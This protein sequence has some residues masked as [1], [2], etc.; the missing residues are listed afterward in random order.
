M[1]LYSW[2]E[3]GTILLPAAVHA[4]DISNF[5]AGILDIPEFQLPSPAPYPLQFTYNPFPYLPPE[6]IVSIL[7]E[8]S[9]DSIPSLFQTNHF[10]QLHIEIYKRQIIK[11]RTQK[12]P[13]QILE[14]YSTIHDV[15]FEVIYAS[16]EAWTVLSKFERK[17]NI[18]L[19]L[20]QLLQ[21]YLSTS[22]TT[23]P[24]SFKFN[25]FTSSRFYRAFLRHWESRRTWFF[26][27]Q[28]W[29]EALLD[30]F[31]I[32]ENSTR[33]EIC[34]IIHLQMLYRTILSHLPWSS[35]LPAE[36]MSYDGRVHWCLK[37]DAYRNIIDQ[38][39]GCG[40]EFMLMLL[41]LPSETV[42]M[43][44]KGCIEK[45]EM[46]EPRS[47]KYSCFDD[48]M[49]KLLT[50]L[51]GAGQEGATMWQEEESYFDICA[52]TGG[53]GN[54]FCESDKRVLPFKNRFVL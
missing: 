7:S 23:S 19:F 9:A 31:H 37:S 13:K 15:E 50:R 17:A 51:D 48:V 41:S 30:R 33:S 20:Q 25:K 24:S 38:I 46:V 47:V 44:L 35:V 49:A 22:S 3:Q 54:W 40:P 32:Y 16:Q 14:E 28:S 5:R 43:V 36:D 8:T 34:D 29:D 18:C 12:Y 26:V 11:I 39:I 10:F 45:F 1:A 4:P 27:K 2:I 42:V 53:S 21:Q 6:L 52:V